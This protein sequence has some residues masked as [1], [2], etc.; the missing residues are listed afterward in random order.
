MDSA[1]SYV[2]Q[3]C[4]KQYGKVYIELGINEIYMTPSAFAE[5]CGKII[6]RIRAAMPDAEIY[7]MAVTPV[8]KDRDR[9]GSFT[10]KRINAFNEALYGLAE[11]MECWYLDV[12]TPLENSNGFLTADYAG[13][14]G[15]PHLSS[16]G[17]LAWADVIRTY[18]N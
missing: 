16:A 18:Y 15:S 8:T 7:I 17:Y 4:K 12:C 6:D 9:Q 11:E 14:D 13:W 3:L 1:D 5:A 2:D 10:M